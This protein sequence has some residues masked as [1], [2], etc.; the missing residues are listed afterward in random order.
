MNI[1]EDDLEEDLKIHYELQKERLEK[2]KN[3]DRISEFSELTKIPIKYDPREVYL[4]LKRFKRLHS[5]AGRLLSQSQYSSRISMTIK[6]IIVIFGLVTSYVSAISGIEE[7]SKT[8]ITTIFGLGSA[9]LSG[10]T[11]IKNFTKDSA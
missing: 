9:I 10:L 2:F 8:Y 4:L 5:D 6:M 11:S 3:E 7:V 1:Y